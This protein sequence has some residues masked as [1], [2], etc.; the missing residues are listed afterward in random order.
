MQ[1]VTDADGDS[2]TASLNLGSGVF[3]V[4][5]DGPT[6]IIPSMAVLSNG[7]GSA[8]ARLDI[9]TNT[10]NNYGTDGGTVRFAATLDG[11]DSDLTS[12]GRKIFY[13]TSNSGHT[14]TG[15]ADGNANG[16]YDPAIDT[17]AIFT[18]NL[19]FDNSL[20]GTNDTYTVQ[21]FGTVDSTTRVD[22]NGGGYNFVG[23]N[24][25]WAE[26]IPTVKR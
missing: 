23:G 2:D 19:N 7:S 25:S 26:F 5:D 11:Q 21:M 9:D 8:T 3:T 15:Y 20:A 12:S 17:T 24:S 1:T 18:I 22:F 6:N 14:L 13:Q 16:V 4:Q 10:D